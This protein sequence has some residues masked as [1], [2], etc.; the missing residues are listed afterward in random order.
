[1]IFEDISNCQILFIFLQDSVKQRY[2]ELNF[3][4]T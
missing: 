4:P 1:M 3:E 2:S